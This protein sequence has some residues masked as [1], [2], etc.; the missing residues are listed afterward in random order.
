MT[1]S[2]AQ[3]RPTSSHG[4]RGD[5]VRARPPVAN[6]LLEAFTRS[7]GGEP[8]IFRAP[9][10]V[11]LIGDHTDYNDG[12]VLPVAL[13]Y[14]TWVAIARRDDRRIRVCSRTVQETAEFDL[15][16]ADAY[17]RHDWSDYVHGVAVMLQ[18]AGNRLVGAD[19]LIDSDIPMG[20]GLSSSAAIEVA[21]GFAMLALAG[22]TVDLNE[23]AVAGRRSENVFIGVKS[24]I[25]DQY[26][27]CHGLAGHA[28]LLDCR[29]LAARFVPLGADTCLVVANSMVRHAHTASEYNTRRDEC[30]A[31]VATLA[32]VLPGIT[33]LRDVSLAELEANERL[34]DPVIFRR[35]RHVVT[36]NARVTQ[37]ADVLAAGDEKAFGEL[38]VRSHES[39]RDDYQ[40]SCA[41]LDLLV[42]TALGI[43]GVLGARLTGG[44]F[45]GCT[46]NLVRHDATE[47]FSEI[48]AAK[49][50]QSTGLVPTVIVAEASSG[51]GPEP[52]GLG[53]ER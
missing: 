52:D 38:M 30:D 39:L 48:L 8:Q 5:A 19:L 16:E 27:A 12:F 23:L 33:A 17:P 28:I 43:D 45:G 25:M 21:T 1:E 10:R 44:G 9:G 47:R 20:S 50:E 14:A 2:F 37:A 15:D 7:W 46:I 26:A 51:V 29:N 41:E 40:V 4:R 35:C 49:Y 34:L 42:N 3:G 36:E 32:T 11:N 22:A 18:A 31:G 53:P 6:D 13:Q 24:G